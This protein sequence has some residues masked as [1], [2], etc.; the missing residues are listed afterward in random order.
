MEC[1]NTQRGKPEEGGQLAKQGSEKKKLKTEERTARVSNFAKKKKKQA[2]T[3][4]EPYKGLHAGSGRKAGERVRIERYKKQ[5]T[6][7]SS[8]GD[9]PAPQ[10]G[11][12][13]R[14]EGG[15]RG[16]TGVQLRIGKNFAQR[17]K[18]DQHHIPIW[19][20]GGSKKSIKDWV[21]HS[22]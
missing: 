16:G 12:W 2:A 11:G 19:A 9:K 15:Q 5:G 14:N 6:G 18:K 1:Q 13:M 20:T 3:G 10:F 4:T 21:L 7:R 22:D 17:E 8:K